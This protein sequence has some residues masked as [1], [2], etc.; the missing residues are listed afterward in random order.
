[1]RDVDI[2]PDGSYFIVGT[3]GAYGGGPG[4][5]VY[6]DSITRWEL[7]RQGPG[8]Q[9]TWREYPGGDTTWSVLSTDAVVYVG[10]HMRWMNNPFAGDHAGEGA[11]VRQGIAALDPLNG[12]PLDWHPRRDPRREGVFKFLATG[13]GL[14]FGSDSCCIGG[15]RHERLAFFPLAGGA[16][17]PAPTAVT[18]PYDHVSTPSVGRWGASDPEIVRRFIVRRLRRA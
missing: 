18:L 4:A 6:C 3:T 13:T 11:V 12:L 14:Y 7:N 1:M 10:G 15:E 16:T 9:P 5:G 2:S 17:I 8:Q